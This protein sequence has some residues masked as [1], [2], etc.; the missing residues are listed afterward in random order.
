MEKLYP[1]SELSKQTG[2]LPV[3]LRA[4]ERRYS[5]LVPTRSEKG[6]RFY[7]DGDIIKIKQILALI[8]R[9]V[10]IN[11]AAELFKEQAIGSAQEVPIQSNHWQLYLEKMLQAI[12]NYDQKRLDHIYTEILSLYPIETVT[13]QLLI[14]MLQ[15][16]TNRWQLGY[17]GAISEER[18]FSTFLRNKLGERFHHLMTHAVGKKLVFACLPGRYHEFPLLLFAL[19]VMNRGYDV[20]FLGANIPIEEAFITAQKTGNHALVF[21]GHMHQKNYREITKLSKRYTCPLFWRGK[22]DTEHDTSINLA[23]IVSLTNNFTENFNVLKKYL[24]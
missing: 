16:F 12:E 18:F 13:E 19:Y 20:V 22:N 15:T 23:G 5:L 9:G 1:I 10:S 24:N 7:S 3:T 17:S 6:H 21:E 11:R 2:V 4:W 14:P 8:K